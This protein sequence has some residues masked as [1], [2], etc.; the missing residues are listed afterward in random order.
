MKTL[1]RSLCVIS[2]SALLFFSCRR[3]PVPDFTFSGDDNP[4][5]S[6]VSFSNASKHADSYNWEYGD[7]TSSTEENPKHTYPTGGI[8]NVKLTATSKGG[9]RSII[10]I[11]KL[12]KGQTALS[13]TITKQPVGG[14]DV[15]SVSVNVDGIVTGYL[16]PVYVSAE[17]YFQPAGGGLP[18]LKS[19]TEYVFDSKLITSKSTVYSAPPGYVLANYYYLKLVWTDD[20]GQHALVSEKALCH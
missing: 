13:L 1:R 3:E 19:S 12:E 4:V 8:F 10:K 16:R 5:P 20:S 14:T 17:W 11:L 18:I 15:E 2:C 9:S 6:E 7:G